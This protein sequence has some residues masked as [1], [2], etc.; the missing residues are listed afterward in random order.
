MGYQIYS[1]TTKKDAE[2]LV[3]SSGLGGH[4]VFWQPQIEF[5]QQHFHVMTYDQEGCHAHSDLLKQEYKME[6][7]A[8]QLFNVLQET[9][10]KKFHFVGHALG[11]FIGAELARIIRYSDLVMLSLTVLNGWAY[12]DPHTQKCFST[13]ISLL[14]NAGIQAYVEAQ[15]LF[16]YPPEWISKNIQIL[17]QHEKKQMLD[18]PPVNN[19]LIRFNAL[20][21]YEMPE[22]TCQALRKISVNFIANQDDFLVP[23][24]Q[25]HELSKKFPHAKSKLL[26]S[27]GHAT[28]VTEPDVINKIIFAFIQQKNHVET[29]S[30]VS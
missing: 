7:L 12:L 11:G 3:L 19:V 22:E 10:M 5:F 29:I 6:D 26:V 28:T 16:L 1:C 25:L 14:K 18:F 4:G 17:M 23:Y 27:G 21:N 30:Q 20:M 13:R 9:E 2:Y 15:A 24:H 8:L